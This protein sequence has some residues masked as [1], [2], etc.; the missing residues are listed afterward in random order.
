M[1]L[2]VNITRM[3]LTIDKIAEL[4]RTLTEEWEKLHNFVDSID[5]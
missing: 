4:L 2:K 1:L 5:Y 3:R